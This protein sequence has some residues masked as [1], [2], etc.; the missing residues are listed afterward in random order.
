MDFDIQAIATKL[1]GAF[2]S[3]DGYSC[4]C[5][6][7]EDR[8]P[9]LSIGLGDQNQL[10]L[11]CHGGC[12]F[13]QI[14][15]ALQ[16]RGVL[17]E[18]KQNRPWHQSPVNDNKVADRSYVRRLWRQAVPVEGTLAQRYLQSRLDNHLDKIP[19]TLRYLAD[20]KYASTKETYPCLLAAV[21]IFPNR[22]VVALL[23][24]FLSRDGFR[25]APVVSPKMMLGS[26][27]GGV[28]RLAPAGKDLMIAEGIETALTLQV[29]LKKPAWAALSSQ[30]MRRVI[31][32]PLPLAR[33]VYIAQ[34]NDPAGQSAA[35]ALADKVWAE[36]RTAYILQ[37]PAKINDFNDLLFYGDLG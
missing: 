5:P 24:T 26:V 32:P 35:L 6:A 23:R 30:N 11:Y 15:T 36:G 17:T 1:G 18:A 7:H 37:P 29:M 25:K 13:G 14:L 3:G 2:P 9:S 22:E 27:R 28:V 31:L 19:P 8:T 34:D 20:A 33:N 12:S 16:E 10:L 4:L 21:T